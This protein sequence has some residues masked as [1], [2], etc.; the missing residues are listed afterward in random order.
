MKIYIRFIYILTLLAL[1]T[2]AQTQSQPNLP[3]INVDTL[4]N[5]G[6]NK[7]EKA[8]GAFFLSDGNIITILNK[9]PLIIDSKT[10]A[11]LRQLDSLSDPVVV[12]P[13]LSKDGR[14]LIA[15]S[16]QGLAIW[17]VVT[18]KII[19]IITNASG[20]CFSNDGSKLY[21]TTANSDNLGTVNVYDMNTLEPIE[22]F[23]ALVSGLYID[24]SPDDQKLALSAIKAPE[25]EN[26]LKTNQVIL[27]NL[28]DK[29]SLTV[30]ETL[31]L[32]ANS[33]KFSPD[34]KQIA[35]LHSGKEEYLNY[36]YIMNLETK[37]KQYIKLQDLT[38]IFGFKV[39]AFTNPLFI[40][41][42][43]ITFEIFN[44]TYDKHYCIVWD[45]N[46]NKIKNIINF[47]YNQ[48]V[49]IKDND[50]L[51]CSFSGVLAYLKKDIVDVNSN[52]NKTNSCI[53]YSNN[54]LVY[55]S[56][57]AFSGAAQIYDVSG[58]LVADLG[59]QTF[60]EGRN[61]IPVHQTLPTGVYLLA[62][63]TSSEQ[64]SGKFLLE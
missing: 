8:K 4:C 1:G 56:E 45:I 60:S 3:A 13:K 29:S 30:L 33:I 42:N 61:V 34:S 19:K 16:L 28:N 15:S 10:G 36:I 18:G 37:Q 32:Q 63:I 12:F 54:Q 31:E 43:T 48:S 59:A 6:L 51:F 25:S 14:Y 62:I 57:K 58:K 2:V 23:G 22:R 27:I 53:K 55:Y 17:D 7:A 35:F 47:E 41:S 24:I 40:D 52:S 5:L 26:D 11:I 21:V 50:I 49:D 38:D 46:A 9:T 64:I 20:Y 44:E 39:T